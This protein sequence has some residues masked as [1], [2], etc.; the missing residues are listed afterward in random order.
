MIW[1]NP[2]FLETPICFWKKYFD[3][4]SYRFYSRIGPIFIT[5]LGGSKHLA[6]HQGWF[7]FR[8]RKYDLKTVLTSEKTIL[9]NIFK[10]K[11]NISKF[12][13]DGH[14]TISC[15][16]PDFPLQKPVAPSS[17]FG[18]CSAAKLQD[19]FLVE[20]TCAFSANAN[21]KRTKTN[22]NGF[23]MKYIA[24]TVTTED[25]FCLEKQI[26]STLNPNNG[27]VHLFFLWI[28]QGCFF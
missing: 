8:G 13:T 17:P 24:G 26:P 23:V 1:G 12:A 15:F 27:L 6:I 7:L 20:K 18:R 2:P 5:K 28:F 19:L 9:R 21:E 3:S 4:R 14:V 10:N 25:I 11:K 22:V 16:L